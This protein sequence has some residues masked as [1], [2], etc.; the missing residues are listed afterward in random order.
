MYPSKAFAQA[1]NIDETFE[2]LKVVSKIATCSRS[3]QQRRWQM[4]AST[5]SSLLGTDARTLADKAVRPTK[6]SG[7]EVGAPWQRV[8][9]TQ[10]S[11]EFCRR[12]ATAFGRSKVC[13]GSFTLICSPV[14]SGGSTI[15]NGP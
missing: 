14:L 5:V 11:E 6:Q 7:G 4:V 15:H 2:A 10:W 12:R 9:L 13:N 3:V 1:S 8:A